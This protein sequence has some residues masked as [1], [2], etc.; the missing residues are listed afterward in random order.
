VP[1]QLNFV[2]GDPVPG[3][4]SWILEEQLGTGG[5][6]EV[7]RARHEWKPGSRAVKFCTHPEARHRLVTH[8]KKV[9]VRVMTYAG[10]HPNIVPLL[11]CNLDG[12]TPWLMYEY[13]PGGTLVEAVREWQT[14][15]PGKRVKKVIKALYA[16]SS[17]IGHCHRLS[18]PI[19]HRDLKPGNVLRDETGVLRVTDFGIGG[20]A[21][22]PVPKEQTHDF[23][24][25]TGRVPTLIRAAGSF[26]YA[27]PQQRNGAPPDPRDDVYALGVLA[28][29]MLIGDLTL[30]PCPDMAD[31]LRAL[32]LPGSLVSLLVHSV[33]HNANRR[34]QDAGEWKDTLAMLLKKQD[35]DT[36]STHNVQGLPTESKSG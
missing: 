6:G 4:S 28:F 9:L 17:A 3:L 30:W 36:T 10:N 12:E 20:A 14:R 25:M 21:V 8:E 23:H 29:Q 31:D 24:S 34:P 18:T 11:E 5:F 19:V 32:G 16:I 26:G 7:W 22:N 35:G 27:S 2:P 13:V 33:A 1:I 15:T